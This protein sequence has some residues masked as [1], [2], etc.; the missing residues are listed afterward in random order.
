MLAEVREPGFVERLHLLIGDNVD[1]QL[2]ED[3]VCL[4]P[5]V[6]PGPED[7]RPLV[8]EPHPGLGSISVS[9]AKAGS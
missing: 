2:F 4:A 9:K 1:R 5:F 8:Q 7:N 6:G 3:E